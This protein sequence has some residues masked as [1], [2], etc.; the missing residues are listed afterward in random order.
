LRITA[1]DG[2]LFTISTSAKLWHPFWVKV[3]LKITCPA[4]RPLTEVLALTALAIIPVPVTNAHCP[5]AF[6]G[7]G[8]A[9]Y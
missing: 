2:S 7:A 3:H 6:T 9:K 5:V 1:F 4:D 8:V